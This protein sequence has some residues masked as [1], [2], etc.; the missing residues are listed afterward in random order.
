MKLCI[1]CHRSVKLPVKHHIK[2]KSV[3][4]CDSIKESPDNKDDKDDD[5]IGKMS[6]DARQ[7]LD[8]EMGKNDDKRSHHD[9]KIN[10]FIAKEKVLID[11]S[12]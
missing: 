9:V 4:R 2:K 1:K 11:G 10:K 5:S 6:E 3:S 7:R 12:T 8:T